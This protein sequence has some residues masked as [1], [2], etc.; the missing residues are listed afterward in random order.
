MT[1]IKTIQLLLVGEAK[2]GKTLFT[3]KALGYDVDDHI[4]NHCIDGYYPTMG[5]EVHPHI[6]QY[7]YEYYRF[8][9]WELGGKIKNTNEAHYFSKCSEKIIAFYSNKDEYDKVTETLNKYVQETSD[10][11]YLYNKKNGNQVMT[12]HADFIL[13]LQNCSH[14]DICDIFDTIM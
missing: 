12:E 9:I 2:T 11:Y 13:D 10:I 8:N 4:L 7:D 1:D 5:V 3:K 14:Q 6:Y